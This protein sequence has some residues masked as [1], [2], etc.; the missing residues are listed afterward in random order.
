MMGGL[1]GVIAGRGVGDE[2]GGFG[3]YPFRFPKRQLSVMLRKYC[4][5]P[6]VNCSKFMAL[7]GRT[8]ET[9]A[10]RVGLKKRKPA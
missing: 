8:P 2:R 3:S 10:P 4:S 6:K 7:R 5:R 9:A 1:G